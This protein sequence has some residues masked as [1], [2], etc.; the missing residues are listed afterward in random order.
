MD[1]INL[2]ELMSGDGEA[3]P[4][5][6]EEQQPQEQAGQPRDENGRFAATA[7]ETA[8]VEGD[9]PTADQ[10]AETGKGVPVGAVQAEREK[11]QAAQAEAET[12]RR[13]LAELRGQVTQ[14]SQQR[15]QPT[16]QQQQEQTPASLWD[17]PD[18]YLK[19]Q[20]T[21]FEQQMADMRE[22]M[23]ES[24]AVQQHGA[25]KVAAAKQAI[26]QAASTPEGAQVIRQLMQSRHPY[27]DLVQWHERQQ[28]L[29]T[30]GSDPQAWLQ[31]EL[32]KKM[33][34][35]AFQAQVIERARNGAV[36]NG[37]RQQQPIT[38]IPPSLSRVAAGANQAD[39]GD[40]SDGALFA[41]A[42]R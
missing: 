32:E 3:V 36:Q 27:A 2:D 15:Q 17:D 42:M 41:H 26:E 5:A 10:P 28:T 18:A 12:L 22:F 29:A 33:A 19:N 14:L 39:D 1:D 11:R 16:P 25:E 21:P 24:M 9:Q 13:E 38:S 6:T 34:D 30:V 7:E 23:S 20:L 35:P 8:P 31:A 37:N 4:A 40:V